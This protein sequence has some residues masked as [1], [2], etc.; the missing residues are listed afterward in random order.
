MFVYLFVFQ[1]QN[2]KSE[3]KINNL[4]SMTTSPTVTT[5]TL[6]TMFESD[7][8]PDLPSSSASQA[9]TSSTSGIA[10]R[11]NKFLKQRAASN[12]SGSMETVLSEE[13]KQVVAELKRMTNI[14]P[15]CA[16]NTSYS[17]SVLS[18]IKRASHAIYNNQGATHFKGDGD[19]NTEENDSHF[20]S[21]EW[22]LK[23]VD[24]KKRRAQDALLFREIKSGLIPEQLLK[25]IPRMGA[26]V[27]LDLSYYSLGDE[28]GHCLGQRYVNLREKR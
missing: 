12:V 15:V 23:T 19:D 4:L 28:L 11:Q 22:T 2:S 9:N 17:C 16:M 13:G 21:S 10:N 5:T 14:L 27:S 6:D 1:I 24:Q 7:G 3:Q 18:R 8:L 20:D 25:K 26:L